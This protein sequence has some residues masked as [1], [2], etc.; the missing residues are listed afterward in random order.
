MTRSGRT[1]VGEVERVQKLVG[2]S[3]GLRTAEVVEH[4]HHLE[5]FET[6]QVLVDRGVLSR[7]SDMRPQAR[8]IREHVDAVHDHAFPRPGTG[9]S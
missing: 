1:R 8:G 4:A 7:N 2:T 3:A 6:G 9:A 5:V